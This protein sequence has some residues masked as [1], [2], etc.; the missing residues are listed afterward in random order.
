LQAN[1]AEEGN[2]YLNENGWK[3]KYGRLVISLKLKTV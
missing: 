3:I 2:R 1:G